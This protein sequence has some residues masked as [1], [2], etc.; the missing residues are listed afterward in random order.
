[1]KNLFYIL[2]VSTL[3]SSCIPLKQFQEVQDEN[4]QLEYDAD[5]L[6]KENDAFR[7]DNRELSSEKKRL[8]KK[9]ELLAQDTARL[10]RQNRRLQHRY[11]DL[12]KNYADVLLGLK[13]SSTNNTDN[14]KL[15]AFLQE[16]QEDLQRREDE[17]IA[18]EQ[19]LNDK[20][21]SLENAMSELDMAR[22]KLEE[23]NKRLI[24]LEKM[25]SQ[26]DDAMHALKSTISD[27][28]KGYSGDELQVHMKDG[29]VYVS[30]E[31][32][33]LFQSGRYN[34]NEQGVA[35]L[36]KIARVLEQNEDIDIMVEGHTDN[37]PYKG[38]GELKDNWDLSVKRATSVVRILTDNSSI[39]P[40]RITAAGRSEHIPLDESN[41]PSSLQKNRRTEIIL[42]PRWSEVF[43]LLEME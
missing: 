24:E 15:L 10:G 21:R 1:M 34:V 3:I 18:S 4:R 26:K 42:T 33:L 13:A 40:R 5:V 2:L 14:R 16:L 41:T 38:R 31:E 7:V 22:Q 9:V 19:A 27:A 29:K 43:D 36:K 11:D 28:L 8:S 39:H 32:K 6:A 20:K 17:L 23:Q 37:V 35:A 12:N 25:L 30:M